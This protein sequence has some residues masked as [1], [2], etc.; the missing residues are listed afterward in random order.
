MSGNTENARLWADA[1]V[2][3]GP[4]TATNPASVS[5]EFSADWGLVGLL[6]GDDGITE[7]RDVDTSDLYAWG[8][9]LV[10]TSRKNFKLT[11]KFSALEDNATTR[12][13]IWPGSPAGTL[14][15][16]RP[17]P[18]KV[19]F[20]TR[21]GDTVRRLITKRYAVIDTDGD[22]AENES[23]L[24]KVGLAAVI[25]PTAAGELFIEQKSD[26]AGGGSGS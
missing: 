25:Y 3:I 21:D 1:D 19:A 13:V 9:I 7:T 18:V 10:R 5:E 16:P 24:S 12:G 6:D 15:V 20:E 11:K 2:Y 8:G 4:L 17:V 26:A 14:I 22:L 23:D